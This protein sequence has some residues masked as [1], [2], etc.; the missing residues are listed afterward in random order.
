MIEK[1][2]F[3]T[4][5]IFSMTKTIVSDTEKIFSFINTNV[6]WT[7]TLVSVARMIQS[8][9][10]SMVFETG[11]LV[12]EMKTIFWV[13]VPRGSEPALSGIT[14]KDIHGMLYKEIPLLKHPQ[15]VYVSRNTI[16]MTVTIPAWENRIWRG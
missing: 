13:F 15:Y 9:V 16:T 4:E 11:T 6:P 1:I 3:E 5:K 14:I 8:E 12:W 7:E 10:E 2:F